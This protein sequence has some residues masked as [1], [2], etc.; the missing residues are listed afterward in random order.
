MEDKINE[1]RI[2]WDTELRKKDREILFWMILCLFNAIP[3]IIN[4]ILSVTK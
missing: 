4:F 1:Y 3:N 2:Y